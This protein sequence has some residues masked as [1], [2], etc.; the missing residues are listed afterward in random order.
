MELFLG[1][2]RGRRDHLDALDGLRGLAVLVVLASHLSNRGLHL[3]PGLD[4]SGIGKSGV[5]LF[6]VL[7]AFLLTRILM[8]RPA[9]DYRQARLWLDYALRRVL[10]IWPVYLVLLLV[11]WGLTRAGV[12]AWHY[13]IDDASLV[14]HLLL[15][16]GQSV[17]WSIPVEFSYYL[18]L[19]LLALVLAAL[20][21]WRPG[22]VFEWLF[23]AVLLAA[24]L[25]AW[26]PSQSVP[27]DIRLGP[28]LVL[29]F[30][31]ALAA[32]ADLALRS[33]TQPLPRGA[34][35]ALAVLVLAGLVL[36]IPAVWAAIRGT[37]M[38][39]ALNHTW[40]L[41]FGLAWSALLLAV[42]HGPNG[43]R[44]PFAAWPMR[45]VGVVSF[46]LYLWHMPVLDGLRVLGADDWPL[47]PVWPLAAAMAA[48]ML[49]YLAF[50][51]PWRDVRLRRPR[52]GA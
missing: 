5:Y 35:A 51:R 19:P 16:E 7:S 50:E 46:S 4:L 38:N 44:K 25:W 14:N 23:G 29:F 36:T 10:R 30:C 21:A 39:P 15:R 12:Q 22:V 48:A 52:P 9:G 3:L 42:L 33:G 2:P 28:Y 18:W 43:L 45:L 20:R 8:D 47:A 37:A 34:W 31:G 11:S 27:N 49:S 40:F 6:F 32:R 1:R 24:A 17:L 13:Q 41:F 26:P